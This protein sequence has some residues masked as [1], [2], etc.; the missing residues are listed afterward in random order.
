MKRWETALRLVGMGWYVGLCI[1]L[2]VL[3]G[4]WL[5]GRIN[6]R[7]IMTIVGLI[8]GLVLAIYGVYRMIL[9][10]LDKKEDKRKD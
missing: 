1:V 2:G 8:L 7:P 4:V 5:D 10:N 9:P 3:G 6:T